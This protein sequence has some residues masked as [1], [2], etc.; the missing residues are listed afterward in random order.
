MSL[1]WYTVKGSNSFGHGS[2]KNTHQVRW[3][4]FT[5]GFDTGKSERVG[6]SNDPDDYV[7]LSIL[8]ERGSDHITKAQLASLHDE[9]M[10]QD[11]FAK[12]GKAVPVVALRLV[13]DGNPQISYGIDDILS[14]I[15]VEHDKDPFPTTITQCVILMRRCKFHEIGRRKQGQ[16]VRIGDKFKDPDDLIKALDE[17]I[18]YIARKNLVLT[19]GKLGNYCIYNDILV[20]M[21]FDRKYALDID[22]RLRE[23]AVRYMAFMFAFAGKVYKDERLWDFRRKVLIKYNIALPIVDTTTFSKVRTEV[24]LNGL[25]NAFKEDSR[26]MIKH[27]LAPGFADPM[28]HIVSS[29]ILPLFTTPASSAPSPPPAPSVVPPPPPSSTKK[30]SHDDDINYEETARTDKDHVND[31]DEEDDVNDDDEEDPRTDP[32]SEQV[33]SSAFRY[34]EIPSANLGGRS[35]KM[36]KRRPKPKSKSKKTRRKRSLVNHNLT[37]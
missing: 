31:D 1:T 3:T 16:T 4:N 13:I 12:D 26:K 20:A 5:D 37:R 23:Y 29:L 25:Y 6:G 19:D 35:R 9:L 14:A 33:N 28:K 10:L 15:G 27:Y 7:I 30:R 36:R 22:Q 21:D 17:L 11:Q 34:L 2:S 18:W 32:L 8:L 24:Q